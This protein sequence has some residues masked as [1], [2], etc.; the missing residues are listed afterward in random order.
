M[1]TVKSTDFAHT[2][3]N[4]MLSLINNQLPSL[5][6]QLNNH[7]T[8]LSDPNHWDG[9]L[10]QK[11]RGEVWPQAKG[12]LDRMKGSLEQLQQQVQKILTN[13]SHAGGA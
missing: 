7:G 3:A 10:A 11:F 9:P 12:D 5:I 13:I 8:Q 6:Q 4:K 1:T 2:E